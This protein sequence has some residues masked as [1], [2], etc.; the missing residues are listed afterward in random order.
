MEAEYPVVHFDFL[1]GVTWL[2]TSTAERNV[3][4]HFSSSCAKPC[5]WAQPAGL[6]LRCWWIKLCTEKF[7]F[8]A[9]AAAL[10]QHFAS[11]SF[12]ALILNDCGPNEML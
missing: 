12:M 10:L 6:Q 3:G 4:L 1:W 5:T 11:L 8:A 9:S 2:H 7:L